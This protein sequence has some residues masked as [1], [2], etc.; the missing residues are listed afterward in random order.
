MLSSNA[1]VCVCV[2]SVVIVSTTWIVGDAAPLPLPWDV[3]E[4]LSERECNLQAIGDNIAYW[5]RWTIE[6]RT[7]EHLTTEPDSNVFLPPSDNEPPGW[8]TVSQLKCWLLVLRE[9]AHNPSFE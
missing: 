4:G 2:A 7:A 5:L 8:P 1:V 9:G 3:M 6:R